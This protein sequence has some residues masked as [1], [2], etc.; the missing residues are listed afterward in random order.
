MVIGHMTVTYTGPKLKVIVDSCQ[1]LWLE[2]PNSAC[3]WKRDFTREQ[4]FQKSNFTIQ[5]ID[6][7]ITV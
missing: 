2:P 3:C 7:A 5:N 6:Q 1:Q 4:I